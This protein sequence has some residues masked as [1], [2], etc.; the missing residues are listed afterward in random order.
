MQNLEAAG[1][2]IVMHIH[3][4]VVI[5]APNDMEVDEVGRIMGIVHSWADGLRLSAAGYRES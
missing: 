3:D 4:E 5:E 2:R 1:C